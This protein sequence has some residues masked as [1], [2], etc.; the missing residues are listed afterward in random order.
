MSP[1]PSPTPTPLRS[2]N[3]WILALV[4]LFTVPGGLEADPTELLRQP[5]LVGTEIAFAHGGDLWVVDAEGGEARRLTS[6]PAVE[7]EPHLSPDGTQVAF[8]SNRSG[9]WAVYVM[10]VAGGDATRLTWYPAPAHP[11]GWTPDGSRIVYA[12]T[13]GTAPTSY[14]RLWTVAPE[15]GPSDLLPAPMGHRGWYSPNGERMVVEPI[16]RWDVEWRGYRGG[17]NSSLVLLDL[18]SLD[19][20]LLPNPD[21]STDIHPVWLGEKV[22]FLSDR[23]WVSNIWSYDVASGTLEQVTRFL[24]TD[25]KSL[26]GHGAR[27]VFEQGG[28]IHLLD[29]A[30]G[31]S[32]QLEITV[33]GDFPWATPGWVDAS[34]SIQA[35]GLSPTGQRAVMQARGEIFTVPAEHGD[36]RNLTRSSDAADRSPVWSPDGSE[37]AWFSD[38]G[39]GYRLLIAAQDGL[40]EPRSYS[41]GESKLAWAPSWSPDGARIAWVDDRL[42]IQVI[43][44]ETGEVTTV[45]ADGILSSRTAP[46]PVWSPDS[47]WLAYAKSFPNH[48]RRIVVWSVE[49]GEAQPITDAMAHAVSPSWDRDGRHLWFL[50]STDLGR[51]AG[52]AN[53]S[54][55]GASPTFAAYLV[56]LRGD[57]STPFTLRSDEEPIGDPETDPAPDDQGGVG[58]DASPA[59]G[60]TPPEDVVVPDVRID[61][62]DIQRRIVAL[63]MPVRSYSTAEAGPAGSVFLGEQ[64]PNQEGMT[65]HKFTLDARESTPFAQGVNQ[66]AVS[67]DGSRILLRSGS[68]WRIVD[69]AHPP[70]A[71]GGRLDVELQA[72]IHPRVEWRQIFQEAWRYQRDYLYDPNTHGADWDAVWARYEPLVDHVQHRTDLTYI[73]DQVNGELSVG[74]SFVGGGDLPSVDPPRSAALGADLEP[75]EGRWRISRIYT[76]ESWN[77]NLTAPLDRPGARIEEG[78][79]LLAVNGRELMASDDPYRLLEGTRDRQTAL[80]V[81]GEPRMDGAWTETVTPTG[82]ENALRQRAWVEDNRRRVDELSD[83]RLAYVWVPNTGGPGVVSFD[84]YYFSQQDRQGAVIDERFNGGGLLDDYMVDF[85]NREQRAAITN[86]AAGGRPMQL[87]AGVLGPKVLLINEMAGSGGDYFPWIFRKLEI[88][89]L[90]GTRTWGGLVASCAPVPMVDGGFVTAPCNGVFEPGVGWVA[91]NEGVPPD[92]EVRID[93]RSWSEG[94]DV[95]LERG[96][97][98]TLRL[99]DEAGLT[100]V[101]IPPYPRPARRPGDPG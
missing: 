24:D 5:S 93:A 77:P 47:R 72:R 80:L 90:I 14:D 25:V 22:Y 44:L 50:A 54:A 1:S 61:F 98:E 41:I 48:F 16:S 58:D 52:W 23:D 6:T 84:R 40:S 91:E 9:D 12:S 39:S 97:A 15:G 13:R 37:V 64:V 70:D 86:E 35:A 29:T 3:P 26:N 76:H 71:D 85:M 81:N 83:G 66:L 46:G 43:H 19:E 4:A 20:V 96:V 89:P 75:H 10:P 68:Q 88:G 17:Q 100:E 94:R 49:T 63:P 82:S 57:G 30:T 34:S 7:G 51:A 53:T 2:A 87:P 74:H 55:M 56:V 8:A 27:L 95:Q 31:A 32:R 92:M 33:R 38:D 11:R 65:L 67:G 99:L 28:A 79:Y 59:E 101:E 18:E 73:L 62:A 60:G 42:R 69:T 78:H 21:R 36:V 45:D